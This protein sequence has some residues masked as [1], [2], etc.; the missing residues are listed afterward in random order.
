MVVDDHPDNLMVLRE[1]VNATAG[2]TT[3]GAAASA[4]EVLS[5]LDEATTDLLL[6]D[7]RMPG[8]DGVAAARALAARDGSPEVILISSVNRPDISADPRAHGAIAFLRK[9][10]LTPGLL[11][12]TW[13][14]LRAT[15]D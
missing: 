10:T 13:A 15:A 11:R 7:V 14:R 9:D 6:M 4:D 3:V 12:R 8:R 1:L 5:R 2:F